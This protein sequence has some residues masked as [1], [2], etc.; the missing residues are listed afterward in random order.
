MSQIV[1]ILAGISMLHFNWSKSGDSKD[2]SPR[3]LKF[4]LKNKCSKKDALKH[5][6]W[7]L[8]LWRTK[9]ICVQRKK[10]LQFLESWFLTC[11]VNS[12]FAKKNKM[13]WWYLFLIF[14]FFFFFLFWLLRLFREL[15]QNKDQFNRKIENY[16]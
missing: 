14:S 2:P 15:L 7:P 11:Q 4:H 13:K 3:S 16:F 10:Y 5:L 6:G 9:P 1:N 8:Y 12:Q